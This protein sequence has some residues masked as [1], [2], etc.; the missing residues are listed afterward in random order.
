MVVNAS[1]FFM[2][3][4]YISG[5]RTVVTVRKFEVMDGKRKTCIMGMERNSF[6]ILHLLTLVYE[7]YAIQ[8]NPNV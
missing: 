6:K 8:E 5:N 7:S 3:Q 4:F 2:L 1:M